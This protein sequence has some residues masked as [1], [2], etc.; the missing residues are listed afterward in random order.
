[1]VLGLPFPGAFAKLSADLSYGVGRS[2]GI[3][4]PIEGVVTVSQARVGAFLGEVRL[5][6]PLP[7]TLPLS[8]LDETAALH[9]PLRLRGIDLGALVAL[10]NEHID[11]TGTISGQLGLVY[12]GSSVQIPAS[13]PGR[14]TADGTGRIRLKEAGQWQSMA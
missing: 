5:A 12:T 14:L 1:E 10:E 3:E 7:L 11:A 4:S 8:R 2:D 13:A 9:G 6:R